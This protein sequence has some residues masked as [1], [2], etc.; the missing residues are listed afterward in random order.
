MTN[1]PGTRP[2][3]DDDPYVSKPDPP[4]PDAT[5]TDPK[6]RKLLGPKGETLATFSDR[7]PVGFHQGQRRRP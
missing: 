3:Y 5:M 4:N 6:I 2:R 7:P 1:I